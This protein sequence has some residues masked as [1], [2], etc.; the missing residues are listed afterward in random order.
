MSNNNIDPRSEKVVPSLI[1]D[2]LLR[3]C[4]AVLPPENASGLEFDL[5]PMT[6]AE[7]ALANEINKFHCDS[8]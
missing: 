2:E 7:I 4:I 1:A 3:V 8:R 5:K 6:A